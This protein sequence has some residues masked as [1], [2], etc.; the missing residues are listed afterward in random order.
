MIIRDAFITLAFVATIATGESLLRIPKKVADVEEGGGTVGMVRTANNRAHFRQLDS[1]SSDSEDTGS[2]SSDSGDS[3][4]SGDSESGNTTTTTEESAP[5]ELEA[6]WWENID[7]DEFMQDPLGF[8][9]SNATAFKDGEDE[10]DEDDT[11]GDLIEPDESTDS[12]DGDVGSQNFWDQI[13]NDIQTDNNLTPEDEEILDH[14]DE[15]N[16]PFGGCLDLSSKQWSFRITKKNLW[17]NRGI[18]I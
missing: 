9:S 13:W 1:E 10:D 12:G 17:V 7:T 3:G 8:L 6:N 16:N 11:S 4:D 14:L 5:L 15:S 2:T 18:C